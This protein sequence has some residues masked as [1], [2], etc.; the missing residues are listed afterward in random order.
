[1]RLSYVIVTRN[2]RESLLKTLGILEQNTRLPRY[3]WEAVVVD[4]ASDDGSVEAVRREHRD[5]TVISLPENEGMPGRNHGFKAA[6]GRYVCLIDDDSYPIGNAI[7]DAT[8]HLDR[9][10]NTAAVVARVVNPN[11]GVEAPAMPCV[12]LGGAS[13]IRKSVLDRLGGFSP[14]FFRQAEEYD[15]SFRMLSA[16]LKIER[17]E[18]VEFLHE[19]VPGGRSSA[20]VHRMDL[21]N[22][23][24]VVERFL[25]KELRRQYRHD[26]IRRYAAFAYAD[27]HG[28]VVAGALHEAQVWGRRERLVGRR[29]LGPAGV[30]A[31]LELKSQARAVS[32]WA[33]Q[34]G[35]RRVAIADFSKNFYATYAACRSAGLAT[36]ALIDPR[37]AVAGQ[38]HRGMPIVP[39]SEAGRLG[40][41]GV[42]VSNINPAQ[43]NRVAESVRSHFGGPLLTLWQPKYLHGEP[44]PKADS[45]AA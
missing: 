27:G 2:R 26:W 45:K 28:G 3:A 21:R 4:N 33:E 31:A 22:N 11:G 18:D 35:V 16:G 41:E 30:E 25:P 39:S 24:I 32:A 42:V 1:M 38:K 17:F 13:V 37:P 5:A 44:A 19:K 7:P 36:V 8:Q 10:K 40:V 34:T 23:L 15:L 29:T 12:L 43:V 20:L 6:R 14:E 9:H